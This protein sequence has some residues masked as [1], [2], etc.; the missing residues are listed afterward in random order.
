MTRAQLVAALNSM[1]TQ[2]DAAL[3]RLLA[4]GSAGDT[5]PDEDAALTALQA[6]IQAVDD[7][8]K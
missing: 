1:K 8:S 3:A 5:T 4:K 6:S 2:L 7:A